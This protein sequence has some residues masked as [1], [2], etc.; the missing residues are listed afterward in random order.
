MNERF[1]KVAATGFGSGYAPL[2]PGTAGTLVGIPLYLVFSAMPW[3]LW[4]LTVTAFTFLAWH[5]SEEAERLFGRKDAQ[6][7]VIDEI[8][9]FQ[10]ALF[11]IAPTALHVVLGFIFF[12]LFD[13]VKP[14]PARLFQERLPG[15]WGVV[16]DDLAAA[17]Y[18]NLALQLLVR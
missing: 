14:F 5:C 8:A 15:G 17:L 18:A 10:W 1:I 7:I 9:G 12:R 11:L 2:A 3:P 16:G 4:L 6:C 13:I